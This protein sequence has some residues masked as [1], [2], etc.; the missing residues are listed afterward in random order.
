MSEDTKDTPAPDTFD[1]CIRELLTH[2]I[3]VC[4]AKK[5]L[6]G[7]EKS[8][9]GIWTSKFQTAYLGADCPEAF[10]SMFVD[11]YNAH[12][13]DIAKPIFQTDEDDNTNIQDAWLKIRDE[14]PL[15]GQNALKKKKKNRKKDAD[16]WSADLNCVGHVIYFDN[17]NAETKAVSIPIS[18]IYLAAIGIYKENDKKSAEAMSGPATVLYNLYRVLKF[19]VPLTHED[20]DEVIK[21]IE[22]NITLLRKFLDSLQGDDKGSEGV[23]DALGGISK[24]MGQILKGTGLNT[25]NLEGK[26]ISDAL[27]GVF[28]ST[29]GDTGNKISGVVSDLIS[30]V[31]EQKTNNVSDMID[32]IASAMTSDKVKSGISGIF[33]NLSQQ[34]ADLVN[35]VPGVPPTEGGVNPVDGGI[36]RTETGPTPPVLTTGHHHDTTQKET[37]GHHG[38]TVVP[39]VLHSKPISLP[40]NDAFDQ[41]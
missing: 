2:S 27:N 15:P 6:L 29:G 26:G 10:T 16:S 34:S 33:G 25:G 14:M 17:S 19:V 36:P 20:H 9:A 18:E 31:S 4:T 40:I 38:T 39:A 1:T 8:L 12:R 32:H 30:S 24:L 13:S 41:E 22:L 3:K 37:S 35:T 11:F 5:G 23:G 21:V 7:S 28:G